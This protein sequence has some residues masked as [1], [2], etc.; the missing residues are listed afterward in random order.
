MDLPKRKP[1]RLKGYIR[2]IKKGML[3]PFN[4]RLFQKSFHDH[5]IRG[6]KIT[7]KYVNTWTQTL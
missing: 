2:D 6:E 7:R 4:K 5:I 3:K 1:T